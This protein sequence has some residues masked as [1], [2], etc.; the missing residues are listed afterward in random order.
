MKPVNWIV[1]ASRVD[2]LLLFLSLTWH[3]GRTDLFPIETIKLGP[4][5][6]QWEK[7]EPLRTCLYILCNDVAHTKQDYT[8]NMYLIYVYI[9]IYTVYIYLQ[10]I[11]INT[12]YMQKSST[13]VC[14]YWWWTDGRIDGWTYEQMDRWMDVWM[15]GCMHL[16]VRRNYMYICKII[17]IDTYIY[18]ICIC[19]YIYSIF[20]HI[21]HTVD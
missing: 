19:I 9:Y 13:I 12:L 14:M 4:I 21:P 16:R 20:T 11:Y 2:M 3:L 15:Y 10:Y 6:I 5:Y 17:Y 18:I 1:G 7:Q 8:Y